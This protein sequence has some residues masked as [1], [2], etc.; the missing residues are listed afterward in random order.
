M[1]V[2]TRKAIPFSD[3]LDAIDRLAEQIAAQHPDTEVLV[4][5][6]I[7][8][9][10]LPI[11]KLIASK[12]E[13]LVKADIQTAVIDISFHRDDIGHNPIAKAVESTELAANPEDAVIILID[14]VI[15]TGRSVRAAMAEV[16]AIGRP[17]KIE[18]AALVDRGNRLLPIAPDYVGITEATTPDEM[19]EVLVDAEHP[20]ESRIDILTP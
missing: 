15:S 11:A 17:R 19:V 5:A 14:D 9:G 8:N 4:L 6:G 1:P 13:P 20:E 16:H 7:A 3:I 18:L 12:L 10:G 2:G